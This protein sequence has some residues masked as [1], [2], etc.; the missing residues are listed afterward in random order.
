MEAQDVGK[1]IRMARQVDIQRAISN[2]RF[3]AGQIRHDETGCWAMHDAVNYATREPIG[4]CGIISPWNLPLYLLSFKVAPA[5]ACGNCIIAK[6]SEVTPRTAGALAQI[7]H[8]AGLP[9]GVFNLVHG[10]GAEAGAALVAHPDVHVISFTGGTST[11]RVVASIAAPL[12]KKISLELGGKVC[13][14]RFC[15]F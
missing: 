2:F 11:G 15:P 5:L 4:I 3:F 6:P 8:A 10:L 1:T 14:L 9:P 13:L 7:L 12:F